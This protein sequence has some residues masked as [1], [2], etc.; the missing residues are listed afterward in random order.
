MNLIQSQNVRNNKRRRVKNDSEPPVTQRSLAD[1]A[2]KADNLKRLPIETIKELRAMNA[3]L[4]ADSHVSFDFIH[5]K[6]KP[7]D[8]YLLRQLGYCPSE[9]DKFDMSARTVKRDL[10]R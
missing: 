10:E 6:L 4:I 9:V 2:K 7:R 1:F 5:D 8:E 3:T